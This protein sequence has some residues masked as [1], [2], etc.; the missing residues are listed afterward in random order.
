M[1][2]DPKV[3]GVSRNPAT[4]RTIRTYPFDAAPAIENTLTANAA[5]F[6]IWRA[7]PIEVRVKCYTRLAS[8]LRER[9]ETLAMLATSEM[10]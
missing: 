3:G 8:I 2:R 6:K 1:L 5:A 4:G 10:G 9:I 7:T